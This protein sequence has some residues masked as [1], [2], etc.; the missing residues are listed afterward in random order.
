ML[1]R[2][3]IGV[4]LRLTGILMAIAMFAGHV[5]AQQQLPPS[6]GAP[7]LGQKAPEFTLPDTSGKPMSL[8]DL[9]AAPVAPGAHS[10]WL[11][12]IFYRGF[13]CGYCNAEFRSLQKSLPELSARGVRVAAISVDSPED[14]RNW[15][16]K[17]GFTFTL[18]SD[19]QLNVI[20]A[21]DLVHLGGGFDG[22]DIAR[23]AEFLLDREG[24]VRWRYLTDSYK[25]R[26]TP[27]MILNALDEIDSSPSKHR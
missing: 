14:S 12:L 20:R 22:P 4:L 1:T 23:P 15:S 3:S 7:Q 9:L 16:S 10:P 18:L 5:C 26:A 2:S 19:Q 6:R 21:Y 17:Q 24:I 8:S 11:L 13:W 25:V 27:A